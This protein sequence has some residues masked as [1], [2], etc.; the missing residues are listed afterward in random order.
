MSKKDFSVKEKAFS[1][2]SPV[3]TLKSVPKDEE[4]PKFSVVVSKKVAK[5]A[6]LRNKTKRLFF[7]IIRKHEKSFKNKHNFIFYVNKEGVLSDLKNIDK[8]LN[9]IKNEKNSHFFN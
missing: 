5:T 7:E 2:Y 8:H 6:I 9:F 4:N 1:V 3:F